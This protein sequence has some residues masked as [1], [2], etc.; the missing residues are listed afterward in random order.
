MNYEENRARILP[1]ESMQ[2]G[3]NYESASELEI[4][5]YNT[6]NQQSPKETYY[7]ISNQFVYV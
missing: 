7:N 6:D 3:E 1:F 2:G 5:N 4:D